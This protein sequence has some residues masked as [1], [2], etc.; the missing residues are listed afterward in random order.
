MDIRDILIYFSY[1]Y[2]GDYDKVI[3]AI[4]IKEKMD[5]EEYTE[6]KKNINCDILTIIDEKYPDYFKC[7]DKPPLVI[8]YYGNIDLLTHNNRLGVVG[9][10]KPTEYGIKITK[11]IL[12]E[13]LDK[14]DVIIVSGLALGIDSL[15]HRCALKHNA[16]TIAILA[17]G[18]DNYYLKC[19]L[20]LYFEIKEK[21]LL[22]SE[23]PFNSCVKKSNFSIRNRLIAALSQ[24][25][26]V[27]EAKNNSGTAI[28]LNYALDLGK[29]ILCIPKTIDFDSLCNT[30][31][32]Q[33]AKMVLCAQDII[34][35]F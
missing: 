18:I 23:Y 8:Y 13:L 3:N 12:D 34:E 26:L 7:L 33:G 35:E 1:K 17:N 25:I 14:K 27:P 24:I 16:N 19:N 30:Y 5:Y 9:T 4:N 28:T 11:K 10:R 2:D 22:I 29:N 21:G 31:I 20:K 6:I 32:Q 15:A